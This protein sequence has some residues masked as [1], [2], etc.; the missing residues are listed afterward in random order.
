MIMMMMLLMVFSWWCFFGI[1][2]QFQVKPKNEDDDIDGPRLN[3]QVKARYVRL[4][5]D[6]GKDMTIHF[7]T[8]LDWRWVWQNHGGVPPWFCQIHR[9][10]K[11]AL[12]HIWFHGEKNWFWM[13][14]FCEIHFSYKWIMFGYIYVIVKWTLNFSVEITLDSKTTNPSSNH[15]TKHRRN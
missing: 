4:V 5:R 6:D 8:C 14:W 7:S 15:E 13:N 10:S 3:D 1:S 9:N 11:H 2:F 12:V